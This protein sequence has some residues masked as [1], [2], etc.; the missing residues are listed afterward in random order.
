MK[1]RFQLSLKDLL[2]MHIYAQ[3]LLEVVYAKHNLDSVHNVCM[4]FLG[5]HTVRASERVT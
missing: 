3:G 1:H 5:I 2:H 4:I